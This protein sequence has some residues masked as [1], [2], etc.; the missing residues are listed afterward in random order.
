MSRTGALRHRGVKCLRMPRPCVHGLWGSTPSTHDSFRSQGWG[1]SP[2]KGAPPTSGGREGLAETS[3]VP[4]SHLENKRCSP[5][6]S[7]PWSPK[8]AALSRSYV[9]FQK[10][11][12]CFLL[13]AVIYVLMSPYKY[14]RAAACVCTSVCVFARLHTRVPLICLYT[15]QTSARYSGN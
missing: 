11:E 6:A 13:D 4:A 7:L 15:H 3:Q 5:T 2:R 1:P 14:F 12:I 9:R 10:T 8:W